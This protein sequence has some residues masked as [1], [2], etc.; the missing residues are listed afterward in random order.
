MQVN[1][2]IDGHPVHTA[3]GNTVYLAAKEAG[4]VIPT[5]C[6]HPDLSPVGS[7]RM[8]LV[9][10]E[11]EKSLQPACS[12]PVRQG[13]VIRT[14][15]PALHKHRQDLLKLYLASYYDAGYP[16]G[17]RDGDQ[18]ELIYWAN[19][20]QV[21][22]YPKE[23]AS[24]RLAIDSDPNP[25]IWV[26][27]NKCIL[28]TRCVR[29]C[30][31]I[32]GRSVWTI[33]GR[34]HASRIVAGTGTPLLEARCESCGACAAYCPTGALAYKPSIH[35][36]L[37]EKIVATTCAYCGVGCQIAL[38]VRDNRIIRVDSLPDA[39]VNG[40]HL[41]VKGRFG[42]QFVHHPERLKAPRVRR[43]L[44]EGKRRSAGEP[45][46][47][48][49]EVDWDTALDIAAHR[50]AE[51][52]NTSG[53]QAVGVLTSAKCTNEENYLMN[54]FTRQVLDSHNIDHCARL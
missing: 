2:V 3:A 17:T 49:V 44:L 10:V 13:Q 50:L 33:N 25:F 51:I 16:T 28:C 48:W 4:I 6:H 18:N 5:L 38:H 37:P 52:V 27:L 14:D 9:E 35:E 19:Q 32:Q 43:Y 15:T 31:E 29:A 40:R 8:C 34:G 24:P 11:G 45:R 22:I 20:Y 7:C 46:G 47:D 36:G 23:T 42:Y 26:D 30:A 39:P 21:E 1:L 12:I 41:C 53:G 54:K